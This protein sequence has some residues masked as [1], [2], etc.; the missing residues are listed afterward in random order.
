VSVSAPGPALER[1]RSRLGAEAVLQDPP[2]V[3]DGCELS[4]SLR[5]QN[6][7]QLAR[8]LAA[9]AGSGAKA[10]V[11]GGGTRAQLGNR[12]RGAE[13][14]LST[15]A[16]S[17]VD[18]FDAADGVVHVAAGTPVRELVRLVA[19][20][21]WQLPLAQPAPGASVGGVLATAAIGPRSLR[22]GPVRDWVLGLEVALVSGDRTRC[23]GRVVKNVTGY[24]LAKLYVGS[25]GSLGVIEAAWLRLMPVPRS[26]RQSA[27][28][29]PAGSEALSLA[30]EVA[31]RQGSRTTALVGGSLWP[32]LADASL[33]QPTEGGWLLLVE[34]AGEEPVCDG[35]TAW[36]SA[37]CG[38]VAASAGIVPALERLQ[39]SGPASGVRA[40]VAVLPRDLAACCAAL[41]AA[42][43]D[44][45]VYP[46]PGLVYAFF[47]PDPGRGVDLDRA[48]A[49][50]DRTARELE[51]PVVL[52]SLPDALRTGR[53]VFGVAAG[54]LPLMRA[55][56]QRFD[57]TGALNPGRFIG[58]L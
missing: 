4:V 14:L 31:R 20:E 40:R 45:L 12:L 17:G 38:A 26:V 3:V 29:L 58:R 8:A 10:L 41:S 51:A 1:L 39:C 44:L 43:G 32:R 6:G 36:L 53:D 48:L 15:A 47:A 5:P 52:E 16:I 27:A 57:P 33:P 19:S 13:V 9:L 21:G 24:D 35:D 22:F 23:G 30:L 25:F 2:L 34:H 28:V 50:L 7:E 46:V 49:V 42:G 56:K 37:A 54:S 11:Q 55:L 18:E